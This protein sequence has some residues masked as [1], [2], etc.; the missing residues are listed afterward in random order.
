M[1]APVR[2]D[3]QLESRNKHCAP[4]LRLSSVHRVALL[5]LGVAARAHWTLRG[6]ARKLTA[7]GLS[8]AQPESTAI[9]CAASAAMC[10]NNV[11]VDSRC[12]WT[13]S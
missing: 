3:Q 2:I 9:G 1:S 12:P 8:A 11:A 5:T 7:M 13:T 4:D 6:V 10:T